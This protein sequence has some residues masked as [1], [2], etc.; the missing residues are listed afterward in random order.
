MAGSGT[1]TLKEI[2]GMLNVCAPGA[3]IEPKEHR[4]WVLYNGMIYRGLPLGKH[5]KRREN[6]EIEKGH[7]K[8]MA[9]FFEILDCAK[10]HLD[11]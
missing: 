3:R 11:L 5:G 1:V 7:V 4:N 10:Q 6:A 9:R 8:K 2:S